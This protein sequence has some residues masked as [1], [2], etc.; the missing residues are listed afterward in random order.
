MISLDKFNKNNNYQNN[1][2]KIAQNIL[3]PRH[4]N[5]LKGLEGLV[6][7]ST[8]ILGK[9]IYGK[10]LKAAFKCADVA[11]ILKKVFFV[12]DE[13]KREFAKRVGGLRLPKMEDLVVKVVSN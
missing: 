11:S 12:T 7:K 1:I 2:Y 8:A 9:T 4:N 6:R 3:N 13:F 5:L 10:A